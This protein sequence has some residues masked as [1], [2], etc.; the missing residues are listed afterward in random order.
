MSPCLFSYM[1]DATAVLMGRFGQGPGPI[2]LDSVQCRGN[3]NNILSCPQQAKNAPRNCD[4]SQNAGV[5]CRGKEK[6]AVGMKILSQLW[7][8][9]YVA[10]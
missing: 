1:P 2:L 10:I 5:Q 3:E 4:E 8:D 7:S 6:S 9:S